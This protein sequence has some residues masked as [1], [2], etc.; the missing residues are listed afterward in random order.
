MNSQNAFYNKG[1]NT[2]EHEDINAH[3][4]D[5]NNTQKDIPLHHN[6]A[7]DLSEHKNEGLSFDDI[8][9]ERDIF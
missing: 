1:R 3:C 5:D 2:Y 9:M 7:I 8:N 4:F 6:R